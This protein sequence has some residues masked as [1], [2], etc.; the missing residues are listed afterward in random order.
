MGGEA[1]SSISPLRRNLFHAPVSITNDDGYGFTSSLEQQD[2]GFRP[3]ALTH[4]G[5]T[6]TLH[7]PVGFLP[8][9]MSESGAKES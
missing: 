1:P 8:V 4:R 7:S 6:I 9:P 2:K 5:R 3:A